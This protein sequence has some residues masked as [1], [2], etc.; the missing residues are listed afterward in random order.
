MN[1][2]TDPHS[3]NASFVVTKVLVM[4]IIVKSAVCKRGIETGAL[5]LL[6]WVW[7]G[8]IN[9]TTRIGLGLIKDSCITFLLLC[10]IYLAKSFPKMSD[11]L[12]QVESILDDPSLPM[13]SLLSNLS[14][15]LHYSLMDKNRLN[16]TG[17]YLVNDNATGLNLGPFQ[18]RLACTKIPIG[19][20]VVGDA[21]LLKKPILVNNVDE[22]KGH[23][24]CDSRS[25]SEIVIPVIV[26]DQVVCVLD[27]D[28]EILSGF[29]ESDLE[30]MTNVCSVLSRNWNSSKMI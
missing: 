26:N 6:I 27:M 21:M 16:W 30:S 20:G 5:E 13:V 14:S 22:Y 10:L 12:S 25:K 17:F 24:R 28:S 1:A 3:T 2:T 23:I 9:I 15:F 29:D 8:K 11:L 18:G 4:H 7:R 19:K